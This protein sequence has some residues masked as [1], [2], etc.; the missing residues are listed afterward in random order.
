MSK[1]T[2]KHSS[3]LV[4]FLKTYQ[5]PP[6]SRFTHVSAGNN[7]GTTGNYYIEGSD[8]KKLM[9]LVHNATQ[10]NFSRFS[11]GEKPDNVGYILV[12]MDFHYEPPDEIITDPKKVKF[13][14]CVYPPEIFEDIAKIYKKKI[15]LIFNTSQID[16]DKYGIWFF[17]KKHPTYANNSIHDGFHG[18]IEIPCNQDTQYYIRNSILQDVES[19]LVK[20]ALRPKL[21]QVIEEI[22]DKR[23]IKNAWMMY[24][25]AK[26]T[27]LP[28]LMTRGFKFKQGSDDVIEVSPKKIQ[29]MI[30]SDNLTERFS[31]QNRK[32]TADYR[33]LD[34]QR[35][36]K[37]FFDETISKKN[38]IVAAGHTENRKAGTTLETVSR[39]IKIL[40][41]QRAD[42]RETWLQ[43]GLCL[44][45]LDNSLLED[46]VEFSKKS[47]KY[48]DGECEQ[49]WGSFRGDW[50]SFSI[51][52]L[53]Y[54]AKTDNEPLFFEIISDTVQALIMKCIKTD[55][56]THYGVATILY[57]YYK[58]KFVCAD[59]KNL[60]W[61]EFRDHKWKHIPIGYSL[62]KTIPEHLGEE[63]EKMAI[64]F[65][66]KL[67]HASDDNERAV[68]KKYR[69]EIDK[70]LKNLKTDTFQKGVMNQAKLIFHKEADVFA[71][72]L[73]TNPFI[74]ACNNGVIDLNASSEKDAF[75]PGTPDDL[76]S[77]G[78]NCAYIPYD[79]N[80]KNIKG[81]KLFLKQIL[82]RK[83]VRHHFMKVISSLLLGSNDEEKFY[84]LTGSGGNGKSKLMTLIENAFGDYAKPF[85]IA[86][87]QKKRGDAAGA[88]PAMHKLKNV[89]LAHTGEPDKD[90]SNGGGMNT[91]LIKAT[92]GKDKQSTRGLYQ[93]EIEWMPMFKLFLLCNDMPALDGFDEGMGRRTEV[94]D[95]IAK[96]VAKVDPND[97]YQFLRNDKLDR[98]LE[99]WGPAFLSYMVHY[100]FTYYLREK[101]IPPNSVVAATKAYEA[102]NDRVMKFI[103]EFIKPEKGKTIELKEISTKF[104]RWYIAE[105]GIGAKVPTK[106]DLDKY[107]LRKFRKDYIAKKLKGYSFIEIDEGSDEEKNDEYE[108]E[109]EEQRQ[110]KAYV[111][112]SDPQIGPQS[113]DNSDGGVR[114]IARDKID[115]DSDNETTLQEML[116]RHGEKKRKRETEIAKKIEGIKKKQLGQGVRKVAKSNAG[117]TAGE[118]SDFTGIND[119]E[120]DVDEYRKILR[121]Q[122]DSDASECD[123][124]EIHIPV[125][126]KA[127]SNVSNTT[128]ISTPKL[129]SFKNENNHKSCSSVSS[130]FTQITEKTKSSVVDSLHKKFT[131]PK[132]EIKK[133]RINS[134]DEVPHS[135][136]KE[137]NACVFTDDE[138][139]AQSDVS[140]DKGLTFNLLKMYKKSKNRK[141]P[142]ST[143]SNSSKSSKDRDRNQEIRASYARKLIVS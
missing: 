62:I 88:N 102:A 101:S 134:D 133:L 125:L 37:K 72:K 26:T 77:I 4:N 107:L 120:F 97:P 57:H 32:Q 75:R 132:K 22:V 45:K 40:S 122:Y 38:K 136:K 93:D 118:E 117:S 119:P 9:E 116:G 44:K 53:Y 8:T 76:S 143:S 115:S 113:D 50:L 58:D 42:S 61:Y 89:R 1:G 41:C 92:T 86:I 87:L 140:Q 121:K 23:I 60:I 98:K 69:D 49:L 91:G 17:E 114:G 47:D 48:Q 124:Y 21:N 14:K 112:D 34:I 46:W 129:E 59:P 130:K 84:I 39:L 25:C 13:L 63:C 7:H 16:S 31:I 66:K 3:I 24:G 74:V 111:Y 55:G 105:S 5:Q 85:N 43:V 137:Q 6:G 65:T 90:T 123:L 10:E 54:W 68:F 95:F 100:Y 33:T 106:D 128:I 131:V 20:Y 27:S 104:R 70:Y 126:E 29:S 141:G 135:K 103:N 52:S 2:G 138:Y 56:L 78:T 109:T 18:I 19:L 142:G 81:I 79:P 71:N 35:D 15:D 83:K 12:D 80:S 110:L 96:F 11:I 36:I 73:N 67:I 82:P 28:Y 30:D 99:K 94:I 139:D 51:G 127:K 108:S 64:E